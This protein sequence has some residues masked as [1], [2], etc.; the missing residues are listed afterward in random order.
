MYIVLMQHEE[1]LATGLNVVE[2]GK[3][4]VSSDEV[5]T[6]IAMMGDLLR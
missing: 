5:E 1:G 3:K 2:V 6:L 4:G